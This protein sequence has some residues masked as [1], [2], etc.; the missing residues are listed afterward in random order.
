MWKNVFKWSLA[1]P[2]LLRSPL[3]QTRLKNSI[4]STRYQCYCFWKSYSFES[5][6]VHRGVRPEQGDFHSNHYAFL[7]FDR[8][9]IA[10]VSVRGGLEKSKGWHFFWRSNSAN[11]VLKKLSKARSKRL[12]TFDFRPSSGN[13]WGSFKIAFQIC[14]LQFSTYLRCKVS[15]EPVN[16]NWVL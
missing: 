8:S 10:S 16:L 7:S 13:F 6:P 14:R 5:A 9:L 12:K 2:K 1:P 15:R 4:V 11:F 3:L